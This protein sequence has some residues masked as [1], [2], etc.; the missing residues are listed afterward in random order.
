MRR[1]PKMASTFIFTEEHTPAR[2]DPVL[3]RENGARKEG[4]VRRSDD[5]DGLSQTH[6]DEEHHDGRDGR[7]GP[8][9]AAPHGDEGFVDAGLCCV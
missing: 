7:Q 2:E 4:Q 6:R 3:I 1:D 5:V 8:D 9:H